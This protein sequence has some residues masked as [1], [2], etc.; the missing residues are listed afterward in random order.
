MAGYL[1]LE[2]R[3]LQPH[4]PDGVRPNT[5]RLGFLDYLRELRDEPFHFPAGYRTGGL[6]DVLIA[7]GPNHDDVV[8]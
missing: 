2:R 4:K 3:F 7:A 1:L 8:S 5:V 6:E